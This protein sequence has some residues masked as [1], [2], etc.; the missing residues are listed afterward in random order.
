MP[1]PAALQGRA[2]ADT[3][4]AVSGH[5]AFAELLW[6]RDDRP[7]DGPE[8]MA[9]DEWLLAH[10]GRPLL[11][12]YRWRGAWVSYGYS[13][14]E[15]DARR[16]FAGPGLGYVRR[17]TGGGVVDHRRDWTYSVVV[18]AGEPLAGRPAPERYRELH[19]AVA[20]ALRAEGIEA[21]LSAGAEATGSDACFRN[22][23]SA[24]LVGCDGAKLAGAGQRRTRRG[25]LHQGSVLTPPDRPVAPGRGERLARELG[26]SIAEV[27]FRPDPAFLAEALRTRYANPGWKRPGRPAQS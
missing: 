10:A 23:V 7:R 5:R 14:G 21:R 17:W 6:W 2:G 4:R 1:A 15:S 20:A 11:R 26:D 25:V 19:A 13:L 22:P 16:Q 27:E 12:V 8:N 18:P 24:D 3:I 9:V